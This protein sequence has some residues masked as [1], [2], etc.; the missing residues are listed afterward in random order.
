MNHGHVCSSLQDAETLCTKYKHN[1]T[2]DATE[3]G[4]DIYVG[5]TDSVKWLSVLL[6][7]TGNVRQTDTHCWRYCTSDRHPLLEVRY[8]RQTPTAGGTVRQTDTHCWRY[9]TSDRHP[10]LEVRYVRQ[11]P[12]A[13][14]TVRQTPTAGGTVRQ[15]DTHCWRYGTSD[16]HPL[17][18]HTAPLTS[19][20]HRLVGPVV[21][22]SAPRADDAGFDSRLRHGDFSGSTHT[23]DLMVG[24]P[25]ATLP[26][27]W[28][29][30][31]SAGTGRPGVS[32]L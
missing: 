15:T 10:L 9:C 4:P 12:T 14:G 26:G 8:V 6:S 16:R 13:G 20:P 19:G 30:T 7:L 24:T 21:K 3:A 25:V 1:K 23:S 27:A 32:I 31:I 22:A 5:V 2:L 28:R 11:T 18:A 29:Y 17:P